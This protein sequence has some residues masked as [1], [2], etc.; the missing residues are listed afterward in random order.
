MHRV[1]YETTD[2]LELNT[3]LEAFLSGKIYRAIVSIVFSLTS[4][5]R[6]EDLGDVQER[7]EQQEKLKQMRGRTF[8]EA[9]KLRFFILVGPNEELLFVCPRVFRTKV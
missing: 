6:L 3:S 8:L 9:K 5:N 2:N 1:N 4:S 7:K